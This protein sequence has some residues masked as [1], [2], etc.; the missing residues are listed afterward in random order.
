MTC[1]PT[2]P[3]L[4][5]TDRGQATVELA[6]LMPVWILLILAVVQVGL[7]ARAEVETVQ[8]AREA[9]R[10]AA[11][12]DDTSIVAGRLPPGRTVVERRDIGPLVSVRVRY[13]QATEV[14]IVGALV[15]DVVHDVTVTMRREQDR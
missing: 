15:G 1:G 4:A 6:L 5:R 3:R 12:G 7:V 2:T 10:A 8:A 13:R 14:A 9:A 11:A